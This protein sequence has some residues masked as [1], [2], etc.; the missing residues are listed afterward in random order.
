MRLLCALRR[1]LALLL[2]S[3][4]LLHA[5]ISVASAPPE[6]PVWQRG[7]QLVLVVSAD[8]SAANASLQR[9]EKRRFGWRRVGDAIPVSLGKHGSAWGLGLHAGDLGEPKKREGDGK[10]PAG[11]FAIGIAFGADAELNTG[12]PYQPMD[13]HDWC[14]DVPGSPYYNQIVDQNQVGAAAIAGSSE[15]MRRDLHTGDDLYRRGFVIAHNLAGTDRGG[16]CIFAHRWRSQGAPT[17][18]CTAMSAEHLDTLLSWLQARQEP[19][20]LLLPESEYRAL[21]RAWKLP[22]SLP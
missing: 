20:F 3:V 14:I 5:P 13:E 21:R 8:W 16:S 9:Y 19:R 2:V 15:P 18:G 11:L 1:C 4:V 22:R 7:Q 6:I 10:A 17:A 12:L